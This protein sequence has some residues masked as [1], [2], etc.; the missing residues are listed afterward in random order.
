MQESK[1]MA[2]TNASEKEGTMGG[3]WIIINKEKNA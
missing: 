3:A 1:A 2:A